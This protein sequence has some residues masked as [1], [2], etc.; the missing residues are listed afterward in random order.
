[1][2]YIPFTQLQRRYGLSNI[3][4]SDERLSSCVV[5][6]TTSTSA[7]QR[8]SRVQLFTGQNSNLKF[9]PEL[10]LLGCVIHIL[11]YDLTY[12]DNIASW[13][14]II[15]D[16]GGHVE[17]SY[18][19]AVTHVICEK[20][21]SA[22]AQQAL[23]DG[24]RCVSG[25]WLNDV[26]FKMQVLPPWI[27]LHFPTNL[28]PQGKKYDKALEW[29]TPVVNTQWLSDIFLGHYKAIQQPDSPKYKIF[30]TPNLFKVE[31]G[32]IPHL[33]VAWKQPLSITQELYNKATLNPPVKKRRLEKPSSVMVAPAVI[34]VSL[35][36]VE[37][38]QKEGKPRVVLSYVNDQDTI[39]KRVTNLGGVVVND[40]EQ[41]THLVMSKDTIT[42]KLVLAISLGIF[43]VSDSWVADSS[44]HQTFQ[45]E[46]GYVLQTDNLKL[47]YDISLAD[48]LNKP[49]RNEFLKGKTFYVTHGVKPSRRI[50]HKVIE[51]AGGS[52]EKEMRSFV[53]LKEANAVNL[54]IVSAEN[55]M[56]LLSR[57]SNS[58][59]VKE[60][61]DN[62]I[63]LCRD[64]GL[65]PGR[66]HRS[67]T[68]YP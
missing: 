14:K 7:S 50:L 28:R 13:K 22:V 64:R 59:E 21:S 8:Q 16:H 11:D 61:F 68:P 24:K 1:M 37:A 12:T 53:R 35:A 51:T 58:I 34:E 3:T 6:S 48:T 60:G 26:L 43:I 65:N 49:N 55:D 23:K 42:I 56:H 10:C 57:F 9:T 63:N 33:M 46:K 20:L 62:Q 29:K 39:V 44:A 45:D 27:A 4:N 54:Y 47:S 41:A 15:T 5:S 17:E 66:Q 36:Q 18:G 38:A 19:P 52:A 40:V 31:Y 32:L 30:N 67:L 25:Y 2:E